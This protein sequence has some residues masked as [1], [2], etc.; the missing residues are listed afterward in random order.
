M[1]RPFEQRFTKYDYAGA[2]YYQNLS[3]IY[4]G[5]NGGFSF[6]KRST[7]INCLESVTWDEIDW[8]RT[9]R[10]YS[11]FDIYD[12]LSHNEDVF[13]THACEIL[14]KAVPDFFNREFFATETQ[15]TSHAAVYHGWNKN[16][17]PDCNVKDMLRGSPLFSKYLC[18]D[19]TI[20]PHHAI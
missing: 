9:Q 1:F 7:M 8:H 3:P 6:R 14:C 15:I 18:Q 13:F 17:I 12:N 16:L 20:S 11:G 10:K 2:N 19:V 4:G 5:M